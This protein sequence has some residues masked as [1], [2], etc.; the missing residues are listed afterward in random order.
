MQPQTSRT[1]PLTHEIGQIVT[2]VELNRSYGRLQLARAQTDTLMRRL[3][4]IQRAISSLEHEV[5]VFRAQ[6]DGRAAAA[7][8]D[9]LAIDIMRDGL[10]E[11]AQSGEL[12][13]YPDFSKRGQP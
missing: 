4:L 10:V 2:L 9:D 8:L 1:A 3:V 11:A 12:V 13:V 6:E 7:V 5:G